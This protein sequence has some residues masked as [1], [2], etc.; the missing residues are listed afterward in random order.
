MVVSGQ[1][2]F[3]FFVLCSS[4][5]DSSWEVFVVGGLCDPAEISAW[6]GGLHN[7]LK[8]YVNFL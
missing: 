1:Q 4:F 7:H 5:W 6:T 2:L 3:E 8:I